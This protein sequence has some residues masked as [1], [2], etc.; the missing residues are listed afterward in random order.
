MVAANL[1]VALAHAG[2]RVVL[3]DADMRQSQIDTMFQLK[4]TPGLAALAQGIASASDVVLPSSIRHLSILP[5]GSSGESSPSEFLGSPQFGSLL[6]KLREDFEH[7]IIDSP[8][9]LNAV[10]A[11]LIAGFGP[12][13]LF[14]IGAQTD[15]QAAMEALERL[16]VGRATFLGA[17]LNRVAVGGRTYMSSYHYSDARVA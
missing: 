16:A 7:I 11:G 17:V 9:V 3:I 13:V 1:A 5:A 6:L 10:D 14:V 8:P 2:R 15:R 12:G 4:P